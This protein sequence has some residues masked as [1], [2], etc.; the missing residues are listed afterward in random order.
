MNPLDLTEMRET[1]QNPP[2]FTTSNGH[3]GFEEPGLFA[4]HGHD[5]DPR[6][7]T[8]HRIDHQ[9]QTCPPETPAE[10]DWSHTFNTQEYNSMLNVGEGEKQILTWKIVFSRFWMCNKYSAL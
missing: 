3:E 2:T 8:V 7:D 5:L 4:G 9:P 10:H 6:F 1:K